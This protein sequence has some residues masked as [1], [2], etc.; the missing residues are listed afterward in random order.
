MNLTRGGHP[1]SKI[2]MALKRT[3]ALLTL[4][5]ATALL[6]GLTVTGNRIAPPWKSATDYADATAHAAGAAGSGEHLATDRQRVDIPGES[7]REGRPGHENPFAASTGRLVIVARSHA[8]PIAG[9]LVHV[10]GHKGTTDHEGSA[11]FDLKAGRKSVRVIPPDGHDLLPRSGWQTVHP[12]QA[13]T[14][15]VH[16]SLSPRTVFWCR[17]LAA[18]NGDPVVGTDVKVMPSST[19]VRSDSK[20]F[21]QIALLDNE[22]WLEVRA[23]GRGPCHVVPNPHHPSRETAMLVPLRAAATLDVL[24]I[25]QGNAPVAGVEL[26]LTASPWQVQMPPGLRSRGAPTSFSATSDILGR[27][28]IAGLPCDTSLQ[29]TARVPGGYASIGTRSMVLRKAR[30]ETTLVLDAGG[31]IFGRVIGPDGRPRAGV[32]VQANPADGDAVP[33]VL[34]PA[35]REHR[36]ES[37]ADGTYRIQALSA[38]SWWVGSNAADGLYATNTAVQ[39]RRSG[40]AEV[41]IV[42]APG[43]PVAG[44]AVTEAGKAGRGVMVDLVVDGN[45]LEMAEADAQGRFRFANVPPGPCELRVDAL[46]TELGLPT[47]VTTTAGTED[48][49]LRLTA[50]FGTISGNVL[51]GRDPWV[52]ARLRGGDDAIGARVDL[53]GSFRYAGLR[54]GTW[55]L[56]A[57]DRAGNVA[58]IPG[59]SVSGG[60]ESSGFRFDLEP[61]AILRPVSTEADE[62]VATRDEEIGGGDNLQPGVPGETTVPAGT[63]TVVFL[64][65]GREMARREVRLAS[66]QDLTV[67]EGN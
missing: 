28:S 32:R 17:L 7:T 14:V 46:E 15:A 23:A 19:L 22:T 52:S 30:E 51:G 29:A 10:D 67:D 57:V 1:W 42:V 65:N 38:G 4:L 53:D 59:I 12:G 55:D 49:E 16:L 24:V 37:A 66:G 36:A 2:T 43:L 41:D 21:V 33:R 6:A 58:W 13:T 64:R 54:A 62:F 3:G 44:R 27:L 18:E 50:M 60:A 31:E 35:N 48:V 26:T 8:G 61:G 45:H 9:C 56:K 11:T 5:V 25:D 34:P 20:G 63:W 40:T 47:P 39:L